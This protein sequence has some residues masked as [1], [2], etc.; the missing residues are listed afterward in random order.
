MAQPVQHIVIGIDDYHTL[1]Y[2]SSPVALNVQVT[3][4]SCSPAWQ[5]DPVFNLSLEL[6]LKT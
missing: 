6:S 1:L 3:L 4:G 2:S 5:L